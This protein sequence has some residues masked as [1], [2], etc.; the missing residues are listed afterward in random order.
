MAP[1]IEITVYVCDVP[2]GTK[3][4]RSGHPTGSNPVGVAF[5][6]LGSMPIS[7]A[8]ENVFGRSG[9]DQAFDIAEEEL[10]GRSVQRLDLAGG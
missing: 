6:R 10:L 8:L 7:S 1:V 9:V 2:F 5:R 4:T 3:R